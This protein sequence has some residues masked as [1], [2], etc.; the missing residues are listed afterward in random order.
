[1]SY[2]ID[3]GISISLDGSVWY[4]LTDHNRK[5]IDVSPS[6][7][8]QSQRMAN[9]QMRKYVIAAK[10]TINT[11]WVDV[12]SKSA[13]T[14]D[15]NFSSAWLAEFYNAN[16]FLPVFV[17]FTHSKDTKPTTGNAPSDS[18][19]ATA[20]TGSETIKCYITKFD[21]KT[22]HR[23]VYFDYVDMDIEFTEI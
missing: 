22:K 21:V 7:I 15:L 10:R 4:K 20:K 12:P 13:S 8:E 3:A 5:Q 2:S 11:S 1:M 14:V 9:G 17:K 16:V 23:N 19:F 18:T 6:L